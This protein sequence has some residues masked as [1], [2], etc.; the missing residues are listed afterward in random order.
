MWGET[1]GY[2]F[3]PL[4]IRV[5]RSEIIIEYVYLMARYIDTPEVSILHT[6]RVLKNFH[7]GG[8]WSLN[9]ASY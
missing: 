5:D 6:V 7:K 3:F 1:S 4:W 2:Q 8:R 9:I